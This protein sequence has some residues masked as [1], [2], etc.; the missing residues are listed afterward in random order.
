MDNG[1]SIN[2]EDWRYLE[3]VIL[4]YETWASVLLTP[5]DQS[6]VPEGPG[7]YAICAPPPNAVG[8]DGGTMFHSL[9]SPLYI[10]RSESSI[11]ARF[12]THCRTP[13]PRL[14]MAKN[15]Y[16][17]VPLRFWF[18]ELPVSAVRNAEAYLIRCFGPPVN[19]R[20]GTITGAVKRPIDA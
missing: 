1:W 12:L 18:I 7:V 14:R 15:C 10:G 6:M 19:R 17:R 20:A 13:S 8:Q 9:A 16:R 3:Q 4:N 5:N 11:K 2:P